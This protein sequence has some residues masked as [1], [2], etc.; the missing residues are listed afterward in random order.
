MPKYSIPPLEIETRERTHDWHACIRGRPSFW[1]C[2][3][4]EAQAVGALVLRFVAEHALTP[5]DLDP[6]ALIEDRR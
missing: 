1:E 2:A 6:D 4:T 3:Q 5:V